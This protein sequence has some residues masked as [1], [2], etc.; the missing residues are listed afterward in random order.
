MREPTR[1]AEDESGRAGT[2]EGHLVE[3]FRAAGLAAVEPGKLTVTVPYGS[4]DE[5]WRPSN[6]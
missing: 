1:S 2:S 5:W 6:T 4:F 3:L